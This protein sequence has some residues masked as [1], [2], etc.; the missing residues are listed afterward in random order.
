MSL[1]PD[2]VNRLINYSRRYTLALIGPV[3]VLLLGMSLHYCY[4]RE[5][6]SSMD[7]LSLWLDRWVKENWGAEAASYLVT[8]HLDF[9]GLVDS[10]YWAVCTA[11]HHTAPHRTAPHHTAREA[12]ESQCSIWWHA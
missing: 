6:P 9:K 8:L 4:I 7:P 2:E 5:P 3:L 11:P 1:T 10:F 12:K